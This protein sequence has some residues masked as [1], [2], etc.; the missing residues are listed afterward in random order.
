MTILTFGTSFIEGKDKPSCV[1]HVKTDRPSPS[2][3]KDTV[4]ESL[5]LSTKRYVLPNIVRS[6]DCNYT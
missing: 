2:E 5:P 3:N 1:A 4:R 6:A